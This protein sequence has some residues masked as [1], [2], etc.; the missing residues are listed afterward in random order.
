MMGSVDDATCCFC[1]RSVNQMQPGCGCS[2][3]LVKEISEEL[4]ARKVGRGNI[5]QI[6]NQ[7][8]TMYKAVEL[9]V[10][11]DILMKQFGIAYPP[12]QSTM[13]AIYGQTPPE[14]PSD[15]AVRG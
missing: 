8:N 2:D 6:R 15:E 9:D 10:R 7:E 13:S 12:E 14:L 4:Q 3:E 11:L 5:A 1:F